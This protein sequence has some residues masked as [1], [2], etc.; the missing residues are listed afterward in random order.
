MSY[1]VKDYN[2][3]IVCQPSGGGWHYHREIQTDSI[4][5]TIGCPTH[6]GETTKDFV[7]E[8]IVPN[9]PTCI[10]NSPEDLTIRTNVGA[11]IVNDD[12]E[13]TAHASLKK[14]IKMAVARDDTSGDL[15]ILAFEKTTGEYGDPPSGKTVEAYIKE[16]SVVANGTELVEEEHYF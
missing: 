2:V 14:Y 10:G 12:Y 3:R 13:V 9:V 16:F 11:A 4:D 8:K 1:M 6:E 15:E 5:N 7:V